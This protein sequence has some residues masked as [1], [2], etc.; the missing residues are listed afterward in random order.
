MRDA[1]YALVGYVKSP[2]GEF[3]EQLRGELHPQLPHLAAHLTILPPRLLR[4]S[5]QS[6]REQV[7]ET[8]GATEPFEIMLGTVETFV[9]ITPTVYVRVTHAS[10]RMREL[11]DRLN[12]KVLECQEE[13]PYIPHLTI[14]KMNTEAEAQRAYEMAHDRWNDYRGPRRI[15]LTE[16]T[17]VREGQEH[18]WRDLAQVRLGNDRG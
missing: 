17:F 6:A 16:L 1:H 8:C 13:W 18:Q 15:R 10:N 11:H 5:E 4:G 14:V 9:P 12:T 2:V 7:E 3:V